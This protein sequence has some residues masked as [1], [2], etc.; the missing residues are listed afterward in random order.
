MHVVNSINALRML[1]KFL[2]YI[3]N[4][5]IKLKDSPFKTQKWGAGFQEIILNT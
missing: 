2:R 3:I 5:F 1:I 4:D